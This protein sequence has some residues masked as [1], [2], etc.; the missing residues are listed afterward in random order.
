M[1][2]SWW[3]DNILK[4]EKHLICE[5]HKPRGMLTIFLIP[6]LKAGEI[7]QCRLHHMVQMLYFLMMRNLVLSFHVRLPP[8]TG[9]RKSIYSVRVVKLWCRPWSTPSMGPDVIDSRSGLGLFENTVSITL[10]RAPAKPLALYTHTRAHTHLL[11]H[12][13]N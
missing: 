6:S 12:Q 1:Q 11:V 10:C 5:W 3:D 9:T 7:C 4:F 13:L 8:S 2:P